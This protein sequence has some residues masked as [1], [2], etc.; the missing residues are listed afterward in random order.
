MD[1]EAWQEPLQ[2][3]GHDQ[4]TSLSLSIFILYWGI[5]YL[6]CV[7]F[8]C[9]T[10]WFSYAYTYIHSFSDSFPDCCCSVMTLC[11]PMDC[12]R[13][14]FFV[15][16]Y[17]LEFAQIH[18]RW[19]MMPFN[20]LILCLHHPLPFSSCLQSFP[21][22]RSF[23]MSPLFDSREILEYWVEFPVLYSESLL[24]TCFIYNSVSMLIPNS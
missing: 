12:S 4:A 19:V 5:A 14:G 8:R 3:V 2:R 16:H 10:R 23:P 21:A 13:P 17:L 1:W 11:N 15:L 20:H 9:S 6:W 7:S 22:S 24:F 18:V